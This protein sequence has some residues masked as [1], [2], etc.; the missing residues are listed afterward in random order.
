MKII[1][2][3]LLIICS[4][5]AGETYTKIVNGKATESAVF[6]TGDPV[7]KRLFETLEARPPDEDW[8]TVRYFIRS[9]AEIIQFVGRLTALKLYSQPPFV[10]KI[11]THKRSVVLF[12]VYEGARSGAAI[13]VRTG[14]FGSYHIPQINPLAADQDF[15]LRVMAFLIELQ[16]RARKDAPIQGNTIAILQ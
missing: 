15:T 7:I 5:S 9:P 8:E 11:P 6:V 10:A 1:L 16:N 4:I 2:I 3:F 12:R 13:S 14:K